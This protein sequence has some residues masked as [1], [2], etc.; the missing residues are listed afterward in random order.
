MR[1][2]ALP[3]AH[4]RRETRWAGA[5]GGQRLLLEV[6]PPLR[7]RQNDKNA[8]FNR[9]RSRPLRFSVQPYQWTKTKVELHSFPSYKLTCI[10]AKALLRFCR[11]A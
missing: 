3:H 7:H 6:Q 2:S 5:D 11:K 1:K 8:I 9:H 4:T 10:T